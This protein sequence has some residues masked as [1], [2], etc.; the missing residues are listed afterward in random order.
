MTSANV[1]PDDIFSNELEVFRQE[2][3]V[4]QQYFFAWLQMRTEFASDEKLLERINDTPLFWI[5]TH[6]A[7]LLAAFLALGR[8]FDQK[9]RHKLDALLRLAMKHRDIFTRTAL[10]KRRI[11]EGMDSTF[12]AK[13]ASDKYEPTASDFRGLRTEVNQRR[14]IYVSRFK[15]VRDKIFA[16]KE[17]SDRDAMNAVL[18]RSSID[19]LKAIFGF[20]HAL[21]DALSELL[22]NG[23][24]PELRLPDFELPPTPAEPGRNR[25]PGEK[26]AWEV[27][28]FFSA[29]MEV[30]RLAPD[31]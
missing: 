29:F 17:L 22:H 25:T 18:A 13:Y 10:K 23:R 6:H 26:V 30:T 15:D 5:T 27:A 3:E 20:L 2:E 16:H 1:L 14:K 31:S 19:D 28:E 12:A 24:R 9:S 8:V 11:R 4:A 21:H 7:L